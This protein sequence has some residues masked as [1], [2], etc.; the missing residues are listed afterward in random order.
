[1]PRIDMWIVVGLVTGLVFFAVVAVA[2]YLDNRKLRKDSLHTRVIT[3]RR[4]PIP[5]PPLPGSSGPQRG[6]SAGES[7]APTSGSGK[8]GAGSGKS[9][10]SVASASPEG[11]APDAREQPTSPERPAV[12]P[13]LRALACDLEAELR[14][15]PALATPVPSSARPAP[16]R[17]PFKA[18]PLAPFRWPGSPDYAAQ[19]RRPAPDAEHDHERTVQDEAAT[20][21]LSS[22]IR[23]G[24]NKP[25][26]V[27]VPP[28]EAV[29]RAAHL[30]NRAATP[31]TPAPSA[32]LKSRIR[33]LLGFG[34]I[35]ARRLTSQPPST[36]PPSSEVAPRK[37]PRLFDPLDDGEDEE[38]HLMTKDGQP[39]QP[40][41]ANPA[42]VEPLK[43]T[44]GKHTKNGTLVSFVAVAPAALGA[45][46]KK[47]G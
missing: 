24:T 37:P 4:D 28:D 12:S 18:P 40:A 33:T 41:P 22:Y 15:G 11:P 16:A 30:R 44:S 6:S 2:Y 45:E 39:V 5:L 42:P 31:A 47:G 29:L 8:S 9:G 10:A 43:P 46:R 26:P 14:A 20:S 21:A 13:E 25:P 7:S 1:M 17:E 19:V 27:V 36:L 32:S 3:L 34:D 35:P 23:E 38:T